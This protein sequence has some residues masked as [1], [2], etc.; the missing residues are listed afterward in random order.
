MANAKITVGLRVAETSGHAVASGRFSV[1]R[2]A[3]GLAPFRRVLHEQTQ[4]TQIG[5][6]GRTVQHVLVAAGAI[7]HALVGVPVRVGVG[8]HRATGQTHRCGI[9]GK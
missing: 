7:S 6:Y 1:P 3:G 4:R 2:R 8:N 5:A 9:L